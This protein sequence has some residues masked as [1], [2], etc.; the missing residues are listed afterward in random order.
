A[1]TAGV[2]WAARMWASKGMSRAFSWA[3]APLTTGQSLSEPMITA[4]SRIILK[5]T[6][7][8]T[9]SCKAKQKRLRCGYTT[10]LKKLHCEQDGTA[11][12]SGST[13]QPPAVLCGARCARQ[14]LVSK[15]HIRPPVLCFRL[16][17]YVYSVRQSTAF[18][19]RLYTTSP[20]SLSCPELGPHVL[21]RL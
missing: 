11:N 13:R 16:V 5:S 14:T 4:T 19:N 20:F 1:A 21:S 15:A 6:T 8:K 2:R 3:Q 12:D 10:A 7:L 9:R 17:L 18:A